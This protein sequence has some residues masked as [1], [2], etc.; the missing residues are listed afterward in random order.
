LFTFNL[1]V[2]YLRAILV[3]Q[4]P[5]LPISLIRTFTRLDSSSVKYRHDLR[6]TEYKP[7]YKKSHVGQI[8][9]YVGRIQ[10]G[11]AQTHADD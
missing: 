7:E 9:A 4:K 11:S 8:I 2:V 10:C 5:I 1:N 3:A 6:L